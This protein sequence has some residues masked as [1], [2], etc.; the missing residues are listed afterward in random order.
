[1]AFVNAVC[2]GVIKLSS[3]TIA[4][5][6]D[7]F[8]MGT[9]LV[10]GRPVRW[11]KEITDD[12]SSTYHRLRNATMELRVSLGIVQTATILNRLGILM[13]ATPG[14]HHSVALDQEVKNSSATQH[15]KR[16]MKDCLPMNL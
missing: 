14:L 5:I 16:Y 1:M 7:P 3:A 15:A 9:L 13:L 12:N 11:R 10:C 4:L 6:T 2:S 8:L